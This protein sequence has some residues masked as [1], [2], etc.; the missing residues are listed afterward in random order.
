MSSY[1]YDFTTVAPIQ[2][3]CI[4]A[5]KVIIFARLGEIFVFLIFFVAGRNKNDVRVMQQS[6]KQTDCSLMDDK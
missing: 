1:L 4:F 3:V 6:N 2:S 5:R